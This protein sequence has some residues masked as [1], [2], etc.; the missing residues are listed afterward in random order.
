MLRPYAKVLSFLLSTVL[1]LSLLPVPALAQMAEGSMGEENAPALAQPAPTPAQPADAEMGEEPAR[2]STSGTSLADA[3]ANPDSAPTPQGDAEMGE[4]PASTNPT[5]TDA[6]S[7]TDGEA[8]SLSTQSIASGTWGTCQ[9]EIDANGKL[10][11]YP[12]TGA[13]QENSAFS[14]WSSYSDKITSVVF[15]SG[16]SSKVK[17][18]ANS[19]NLFDSLDKVTTMDL[20]G[21][22]TSQVTDMSYMFWHCTSLASL[23][24]SSFNT[25]N[26]TNMAYMFAM[27]N[28][29]Y[30]YGARSSLKSLSLSG[31]NTSKVTSMSGMFSGCCSLESLNV[32]GFNT[33]QATDMSSMFYC[34]S[35]LKSLDLSKFD[36]SRVTDMYSMFE[37]C[38][39]LAS[40]NLSGF[41]TSQVTNMASMFKGCYS[42]DSLNLSGFNTAQVTNMASMFEG[43]ESLATLNPTGFSTSQV[44][45]ME[46]MF[47]NCR[48]LKSLD[49]SGWNTSQVTDMSHMFEDCSKLES[50]D[51]SGFNTAQVTTMD[52]MYSWCRPASFK[53]G[54]SYA[55]KGPDMVPEAKGTG[56]WWSNNGAKWFTKDEIASDRSGV[57]DTYT[58]KWAASTG[59]GNWGTCPCEIINGVLTIHPGVG[60]EQP[61]TNSYDTNSAWYGNGEN[62]K[63][64]RF[65]AEGGRKVVLPRNC[66]SLF[67]DFSAMTS[68][69]LSGCDVS[70]VEGMAGM[71]SGCSSLASVSGVSGWDN[72]KFTNLNSMFEG[73]SSL[74]S[75]DVSNWNMSRVTTLYGTFSGCSSLTS[76]DVS[77]WSTSR[78][79]SLYGTFRGCSSLSSL[80]LS[81]WNTSSVTTLCRT[82]S[83][84]SSLTSVGDVSGWDMPKASGNM[85]AMFYGCSSLTTLDLSRWD[86]SRMDEFSWMFSGCSSLTT[87]DISGWDTSNVRL[88]DHPDIPGCKGM[89]DGCSKLAY[90]KVG[91]GYKIQTADMVPDSTSPN[92]MWWSTG[93]RAWYTK[94]Q[95]RSSRS[96]VADTYV[97]YSRFPDVLASEWYAGV[98]SQ[99]VGLGLLSGYGNGN[100][101][102]NDP[103]TRGQVA[104]VLWNMAN[105]PSAGLGARTFPDVA[106]DKYYYDAVRWASGAGVVSGYGGGTRFGPDDNVTREQLAAMLASYARNVAHRQVDGSSDDYSPMLDRRMVSDWAQTSV[107]WCFRNGILSGSNRF[108][109]PQS[110]AS[111]AEAAKMVVYLHDL[112]GH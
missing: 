23:D 74:T 60:E 20:S 107:G 32:S 14:P 104:V 42:L 19:S 33:S 87:L 52:S 21:A 28:P 111:R 11:V 27:P 110:N 6:T 16:A 77:S 102:P 12:G 61:G 25:S 88:T 69:D 97:G 94:D 5:P 90:L 68:V 48:A 36:V 3:G 89:Y 7:E 63:S 62:V 79:T 10:T 59:V 49:L 54:S 40:L 2:P 26:V 112:L 67:K 78:V 1:V 99:A 24:L 103:I 65:V 13:S 39:S 56:R 22:D 100:F 30:S 41:N 58:L 86:T 4:A 72:A 81:N 34:C 95:I 109:H 43:C 70:Q 37:G 83:D 85:Q 46:R 106:A 47:N 80:D 38:T 91:P 76:L 92:G 75:L 50:L 51:V 45:S 105:R 55:I 29:Q 98:V 66:T 71:F 84:C 73:C 96:R 9:W 35:Q 57:A 108:I 93:D 53:V 31:W 17:L 18:P 8:P 15:A 44:T 82:F 101:G 64:V